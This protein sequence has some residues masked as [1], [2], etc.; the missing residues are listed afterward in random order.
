MTMADLLA[1][2]ARINLA[3][4]AGI[5]LVIVLR[6]LAR[7]NFGARVTYAL[8]MAP[9]IAGLA[10]LLPPRIR[11]EPAPPAAPVPT[12]PDFALPTPD[13]GGWFRSETLA[14]LDEPLL[15]LTPLQALVALWGLGAVAMFG[16]V[17][18]R[19]SRFISLAIDGG[20]GP[21][22]IGVIL[23]KI[24]RPKD[25]DQRFTLAEQDVVLEHER[26][27]LVRQDPR[28]NGLVA[29][30]QCV[31]WFNPLM[32]LGARLMR[33][34]QEMACDEAVISRFPQARPVYAG[35][36]LKTQ[37]VNRPL[38]L[39]CYWPSRTE[40]PLVERIAMLK[41]DHFPPARRLA[42]IASVGAFSLVLGAAAWAAAPARVVVEPGQ[43]LAGDPDCSTEACL[44]QVQVDFTGRMP[45]RSVAHAIAL[46]NAWQV[47][48]LGGTE[49]QAGE[50]L[51][52]RFET[53]AAAIDPA[54][55][56]GLRNVQNNFRL[57]FSTSSGQTLE[58]SNDTSGQT[59]VDGGT[60]VGAIVR[61]GDADGRTKMIWLL[62]N[63]GA[64]GQL[65]PGQIA[66][67]GGLAI[68]P[69]P[70]YTGPVSGVPAP[71]SPLQ[72]HEATGPMIVNSAPPS[73]PPAEIN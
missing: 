24:V 21:A 59:L 7:R 31:C 47:R 67:G 73:A 38:P 48:D 34:D 69:P 8:W 20:A 52:R 27:H 71:L 44:S 66:I 17:L 12:L 55:L 4:A 43:V 40:H 9:G 26:T 32:H 25:F 1:A 50:A 5:L 46:G 54:F 65:P 14:A 30:L 53:R 36:L 10:S 42:G 22:V 39:G 64:T 60:V 6:P 37:L 19:Q 57:F 3:L 2:M 15:V 16:L 63:G 11:L 45:A 13:A 35:A 68:T 61:Q 51:Q 49:K 58:F 33:I 18:L 56:P 28:I 72:N 23:P 70:G 62:D 29:V 41:K